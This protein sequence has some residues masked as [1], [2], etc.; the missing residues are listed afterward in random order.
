VNN[1]TV[2]SYR[3]DFPKSQVDP[4]ANVLIVGAT[5]AET[6]VAVTNYPYGRRL[7]CIMRYWLEYKKGKGTR[8][9]AQTNDPKR[10]GLFWNKPHAETYTM[11]AVVLHTNAEGHVKTRE[12]TMWGLSVS[13]LAEVDE[14]LA[15]IAAFETNYAEALT[16]ADRGF[17]GDARNI[18]TRRSIDLSTPH[19]KTPEGEYCRVCKNYASK[20]T[21]TEVAIAEPPTVAADRGCLA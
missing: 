4:D 17:I 5:S 1:E 7:R 15:S 20:C 2:L 3:K 19:V 10:T 13:S 8:L 9:V 16:E 12:V 6:S 11:G 18:V 14:K 21:G